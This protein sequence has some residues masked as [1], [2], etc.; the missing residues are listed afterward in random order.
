MPIYDE[1]GNTVLT[2]AQVANILAGNTDINK[3]MTYNSVTS[4]NR[5]LNPTYF[6]TGASTRIVNAINT[7]YRQSETSNANVQN[8]YSIFGNIILDTTI[9][10]NAQIWEDCKQATG[11]NSLIEAVLDMA[12]QLDTGIVTRQAVITALGYT[13]ADTTQVPTNVSQ[14][15]ND[16]NYAT[17][18]FVTSAIESISSMDIVI[19]EELPQPGESGK[20][21]LVLNDSPSENNSYLEYIWVNSNW[22]QVGSTSIDFSDY[23]NKSQI[24]DKLGQKQ[25][26]LIAGENV[27]IE[28]ETNTISVTIPDM[29][30]ANITYDNDEYPTVKAALDKLLY[31]APS[32]TSFTSN[33]SNTNE[34]GSIINDI[35]FNWQYNKTIVSQTISDNA[36]LNQVLEPDVRTYSLSELGLQSNRTYRIT[37]NDGTKDATRTL[38]IN[39]AL[40]R[41]FGVSEKNTLEDA[42]ILAF[43]D[44]DFTT[45]RKVTKTFNCSG[46]KY[47]YIVIPTSYCSGITFKVGGLSFSAMEVVTRNVVNSSGHSASYNIYRPTSIQTGSAISVEVI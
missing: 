12:Q 15:T 27:D 37:G 20:I 7:C 25:D 3:S 10:A 40:R 6:G 36:S 28:E 17:E 4:R 43:T 18:S 46:G 5:A 31:V 47:F 2:D 26:K 22:E 24:D 14:L 23:Y 30:S 16:S 45:N 34:L 8:I 33:A 35:T 39:F 21:Y 42:D 44:K 1:D 13:P 9:P 11:K 19:V 41:Y 32:V 38:S 29:D